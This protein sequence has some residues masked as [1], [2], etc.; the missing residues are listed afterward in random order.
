MVKRAP[1][2]AAHRVESPRRHADHGSI[3][4]GAT[5]SGAKSGFEFSSQLDPQ[6]DSASF[7]FI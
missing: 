2:A 7:I 3:K 5:K 4:P 1:G 6:V